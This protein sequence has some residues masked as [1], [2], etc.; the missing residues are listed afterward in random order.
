M[1]SR[2]KRI[3]KECGLRDIRFHVLRH[4]FATYSLESGIH[5][6]VLSELMGHSSVKITMDR[7]VHLSNEFKEAQMNNLQYKDSTSISRQKNGQND[8][9][10]C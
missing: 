4:T 1:S 7:Y 6:K 8:A 9:E 3:L 5:T 10:A 2:F